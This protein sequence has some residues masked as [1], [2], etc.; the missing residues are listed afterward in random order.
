MF[1]ANYHK[2]DLTKCNL[3]REKSFGI[4]IRAVKLSSRQVWK[5]EI[6]G[7][8]NFGAIIYV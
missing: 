8:E 7:G 1:R 3:L 5:S 2:A 4:I 6:Y